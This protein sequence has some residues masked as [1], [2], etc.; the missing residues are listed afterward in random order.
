MSTA[1]IA[2]ATEAEAEDF[3]QLERTLG[4]AGP[5]EVLEQLRAALDRRGEYRAL[6]DAMLLDARRELG[7]PLVAQG[8]LTDLPEPARSRFEDR[9]IEALRTI[10]RKLIAAG[11][12]PEAWP[13]FRL[14]GETEPIRE[15]IEAY[16]PPDNSDDPTLNQIIEIAFGQAAHPRKGF[17][18]VLEHYGICAAITAFEQ[19]PPDLGH[20]ADAAERLIRSLHEQLRANLRADIARTEDE[21][22]APETASIPEL[23]QGRDRLFADDNYHVDLSHLAS[24]VRL[25]PLTTDPQILRQAVELTDYGRRLSPRHRYEGEPPFEQTYEDHALYLRGLLGENV[26]EAI[27]HFTAKL[28]PPDP[29]GYMDYG[30]T[31]P[32]QSLVRLLLRTGRLEQAIEVAAQHLSGV[33]EGALFVPTAFQLCQQAGRFDLMERIAREKGDLVS[34]VAAILKRDAKLA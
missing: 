22:S 5:A 31:V 29:D 2:A 24:V 16:Q 34:F 18:M 23:L 28:S 25:A 20:R 9:Y 4:Q 10:G 8:S 14:L 1:T 26:E 7:L 12:I 17:A 32:A 19:L 11:R 15:A 30:Q 21:S 27:A 33:P 13:Y 3:G 6:L